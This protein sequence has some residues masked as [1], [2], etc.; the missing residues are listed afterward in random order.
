MVTSTTASTMSLGAPP[1]SQSQPSQSHQCAPVTQQAVLQV[2]LQAA[3]TEE[4][5]Q[6][7]AN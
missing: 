4:K 5:L 7:L 1:L 6:H 2:P 3:G